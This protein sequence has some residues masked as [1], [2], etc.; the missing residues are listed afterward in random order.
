VLAQQ[1]K[2]DME[3]LTRA[4]SN[5]LRSELNS[6]Y[7]NFS[8]ACERIIDKYDRCLVKP[9]DSEVYHAVYLYLKGRIGEDLQYLYD[10]VAYG[11][12]LPI[13][14]LDNKYIAEDSEKLEWLLNRY[15]FDA[16]SGNLTRETWLA[17][18]R[19]YF[20]PSARGTAQDIMLTFLHETFNEVYKISNHKPSWMRY[21]YDNPEILSVDPCRNMGENW[22]QG[23]REYIN[24]LVKSLQISDKS[25]FWES[26]IK[27]CINYVSNK[28]DAEFIR[29]INDITIML[30]DAPSYINEGMSML[31]NRY[32]Q[33]EDED[34]N[35]D[36]KNLAFSLWKNPRFRFCGA[37]EWQNVDAD[38]WRMSLGW[39][40]FS[41]KISFTLFIIFSWSSADIELSPSDE[42]PN[43][44]KIFSTILSPGVIFL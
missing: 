42:V 10:L 32:N 13:E 26:M 27:S 3:G 7:Q 31:L 21:L 33:C 12:Y 43:E 9:K 8:S 19:A 6:Q 30:S 34:V 44:P 5:D 29:Y 37:T 35:E 1:F 23:N 22:F 15:S 11:L 2:T 40:I 17:V 36:L 14:V 39:L 20:E 24:S 4:L 41:F 25:W 16:Y 18:L 28:P 38:V